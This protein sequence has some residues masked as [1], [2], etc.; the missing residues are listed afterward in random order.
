[1]EMETEEKDDLQVAVL[2]VKTLDASNTDE[3]KEKME[4]LIEQ[5]PCIV[6]DMSKG[7]F[8]DSSGCGALL[9]SFRKA[10]AKG[11]DL[12]LSCVQEQVFSLFRMVKL[13]EVI[14]IFET[15]DEAIQAF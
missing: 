14:D 10:A 9:S 6:L 2:P 12:K 7:E 15:R 8:L 4:G 5:N 11:G 13:H 1:M 3:F